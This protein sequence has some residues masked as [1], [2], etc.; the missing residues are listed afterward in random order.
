MSAKKKES[1]R[2]TIADNRRAR[3][4]YH[5]DEVVE[6]GIVLTGT[7]VK[8]LRQGQASIAEAYVAVAGDEL[9]LVN[10]NIPVYEAANRENHHPNRVRRLLLH[11]REIDKAIAAV[12]R[13]GRSIIPLKLYFNARGLVKLE[14]ALATGKKLHDKRHTSK[15]RDW[16]RDQGRLM[17]DRG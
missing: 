8:S 17:R 1:G 14:F 3:Y 9:E 7:E 11:R 6:A 16:K 13:Q 12:N 2:K 4:D 5:L 10:A 15:D